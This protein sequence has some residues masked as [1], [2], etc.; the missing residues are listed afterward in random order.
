MLEYFKEEI[1]PLKN[2]LFRY[3][4]SFVNDINEAEDIVQD[5]F[6]KIW[7]KRQDLKKINNIEAWSMTITRNLSLDKVKRRKLTFV[8][9]ESNSIEASG[10]E[11]PEDTVERS[12]I[13]HEMHALINSLSEKQ[14]QVVFLRD[15]EGYSYQEIGD[16]MGLDLN[17]VKIT[18][19]RARENLRKKLLNTKHYEL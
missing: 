13:V 11:T 14:K 19:F 15:I 3:A 18:L 4:K 6:L 7:D 5:V 10:Q 17:L 9:H 1:L 16:M 12:E 2:K 8:G